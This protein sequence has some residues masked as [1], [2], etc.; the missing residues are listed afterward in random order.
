LLTLEKVALAKAVIA[1]EVEGLKVKQKASEVKVGVG[2]IEA[3][4]VKSQE[5][6][7]WHHKLDYLELNM[8]SLFL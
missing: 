8:S 7:K 2:L 6:P 1:V 3:V 5:Q 4:L